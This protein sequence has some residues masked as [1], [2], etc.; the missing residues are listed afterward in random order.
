[1]SDSLQAHGLQP[2]GLLCSWDC[3]R[4][5]FWS[6][7]PCPPPGDLPSQ[8]WNPCLLHWQA[9]SLPSEPPGQPGASVGGV[10]RTRSFAI[11]PPVRPPCVSSLDYLPHE[12]ELVWPFPGKHAS[13]LSQWCSLSGRGLLQREPPFGSQVHL[14]VTCKYVQP[15]NLGRNS[16]DPFQ[17]S[18]LPVDAPSLLSLS[19]AFCWRQRA[20]L[21]MKTVGPQMEVTCSS[22]KLLGRKLKLH[23]GKP[24]LVICISE[25][26]TSVALRHW[27]LRVDLP[28]QW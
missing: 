17:A 12:L 19:L 14:L 2:A 27:C 28:L 24:T 11:R 20:P 26:P 6:R 22:C 7:L 16:M 9:A 23:P 10:I 13:P 5:Q 15:G 18:R 1:M 25:K 8:G 21:P 4:Q 3:P